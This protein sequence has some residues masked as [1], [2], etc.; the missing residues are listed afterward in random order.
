MF[1][2][3]FVFL[4]FLKPEPQEEFR[5]EKKSDS[6][7]DSIWSR[8]VQPFRLSRDDQV[9]QFSILSTE[10]FIPYREKALHDSTFIPCHSS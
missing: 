1:L 9:C 2:I 3:A 5:K 6:Q 8:S 4:F 10:I 7:T